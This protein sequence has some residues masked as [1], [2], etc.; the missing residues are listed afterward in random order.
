MVNGVGVNGGRM[1]VYEKGWQMLDEGAW[2]GKVT[3][4]KRVDRIK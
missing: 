1:I 2:I 4:E 3:L